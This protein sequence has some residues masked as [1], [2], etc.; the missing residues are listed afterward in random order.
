MKRFSAIAAAGAAV[1]ASGILLAG[2]L[3]GGSSSSSP[4]P[5]A[6]APSASRQATLETVKLKVD[7]MWCS[8][9]A[10]FVHQALTRTP[11]VVEAKISAR[12]GAAVVTFDPAKVDVAALVAATT[13]YGYPSQVIQ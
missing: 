8:S 13:N 3:V 11:G 7:G 12:A 1:L 5:T 10:Y 6:A 9:C 4:S 2:N